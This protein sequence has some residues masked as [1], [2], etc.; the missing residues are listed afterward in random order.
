MASAMAVGCSVNVAIEEAPTLTIETLSQFVLK[1]DY[2]APV[3]LPE[4]TP[5][6]LDFTLEVESAGTDS[7]EGSSKPGVKHKVEWQIIGDHADTEFVATAGSVDVP[8]DDSLFSIS[9]TARPDAVVD[10]D[11]PFRLRI[12][13]VRIKESAT[14][15]VDLVIKDNTSP[16][17]L[18]VHPTFIN[19]GTS[20]INTNTDVEVEL[21]NVG[22]AVA[23]NSRFNVDGTGFTLVE[24]GCGRDLAAGETCKAKVR[25]SSATEL[26]GSGAISGVSNDTPTPVS[27][28]MIGSAISIQVQLNDTPSSRS[29]SIMLNTKVSGPNVDLY[30]FKVG[31]A[32]STNCSVETG[33]S[34]QTAHTT[35]IGSPLF[36]DGSYRL[37]VVGVS[38]TGVSQPL[39]QATVYNWIMDTTR[40]T[41][42]ISQSS[43]QL[44]PTR[45]MPIRF[46][47]AWS[48][49]INESTF[50]SSD[51][52]FIGT[53]EV[54]AYT[55]TKTGSQTW[56]VNV[57]TLAQPGTVQ[58]VVF[59]DAVMD[60]ADNPSNASVASDNSVT[61]DAAGPDPATFL[62][63][64]EPE[65]INQT[66]VHATW[67]P[68]IDD[69]LSQ[70]EIQF[71]SNT[72]CSSPIGSPV[73]L[74]KTTSTAS[75]TGLHNNTFT[76]RIRSL[77]GALNSSTS[78]CSPPITIDLVQPDVSAFSPV[79]GTIAGTPANV[80]VT[81]N[82]AMNAE[83]LVPARFT[84][85]CNGSGSMQVSGVSV[86]SA[87]QAR[88]NL[89]V[90]N[91]AANNERCTITALAGSKDVAGNLSRVGSAEY[92][93]DLPAWILSV[94][95]PTANGTYKAGDVILIDVKFNEI[96]TLSGAGTPTLL[97]SS[98][99]V[100][101]TASY[102]SGS[103]TTDLRFSYTVQ[104]GDNTEDL[105]YQNQSALV[106]NGANLRDSFGSDSNLTLP[107]M[108]S[109]NSLAGAKAII[110]D[111][112]PPGPFYITGVSGGTDNFKDI[113]LTDATEVRGDWTSATDAVSYR[114]SMYADDGTTQLCTS[115][116]AAGLFRVINPCA[117]TDLLYYKLRVEAFDA[118]GN[119]RIADGGFFRF[120]ALTGAVISTISDQPTGLTN[121]AN[122]SATVGGDNIIQY[123]SKIGPAASTDCTD[124]SG[125][126]ALT[127]VATP[128]TAN[129]TAHGNT[130]I[131]LCVLGRNVGLADQSVTDPTIATWTQ[132][133]TRPTVTINQR[134]GQA[135]PINT[136]PIQYTVVFSEA[137]SPGTFTAADITQSGTA[138]GITW[139]LST[140]D[141]ISWTA[142][143]TSVT[144]AGTIIPSIAVNTVADPAGNLNFAST[145]TDNSVTYDLTKPSVTVNQ[146]A[147]QTDPV[148]SLPIQFTVVFSEA[149]QPASF[150]VSD[151]RQ[152]GS[153]SGIVWNLINVNST[154]WTLQATSVG[155]AG[156][157]VPSI[158]ANQVLDIAGNQNNASTSTDNS[159]LYDITPPA[160]ATVPKWAVAS[161]SN[162]TTM[163]AQW[164]YSTSADRAS[165]SVRL[166]SDAACGTYTGTANAVGATVGTTT[167]TG[168]N[169]N[170]YTFNV[171]TTDTAGN[172]STSPCSG[173]M[174]IDTTAPTITNVTSATANGS[175]RVGSIIDVR[176]TFSEIVN[177]QGSPT[178]ALNT[179]PAR[180]ATYSGG[181]GSTTLVFSYT[182][183]AGD[184]VADLNY[185]AT[186]SLT[187]SA[188]ITI[189]DRAG[190][191]S[192]ITL[193][194]PAG[195]GSLGTNKNIEIDTSTPVISAFAVSTASP[196][197][198]TNWAITSTVNGTFTKYC[199]LEN[200]STVSSCSWIN[201]TS[202]P[203]SFTVTSTDG[204]KTLSLWVQDAA[205][206][207]SS[208]AASNSVTL[209]TTPPTAA[210]A[211]QP[212]GTSNKYSLN[213]DVGGTGVTLY[214]YKIGR[215]ST[216]TCSSATGY[217]SD[218]SAS[219]NV[220]ENISNNVTYPNGDIR[221]CVVG[222]D[223]AG[224][225][226][227]Y[228]SATTAQWT[229]N[230]PTVGFAAATSSVNEFG[231]PTHNVNVTLGRAL[232][233]TADVNVLVDYSIAG[234]G[235]RPATN[236]S[237]FT[238]S[239]GTLT[240]SAGVTSR[241]I[242]IPIL[243]DNRQEYDE[244]FAITLSNIRGALNGTHVSHT[245]T[246]LDDDPNPTII[247][248]DVSAIEGTSNIK[249][250]ATLSHA[251]DL[252]TVSFNW[253]LGSCSGADCATSGT[254]YSI[255]P[256]GGGSVSFAP[257]EVSKTFPS[258]A[259]DGVDSINDAVD[260][261]ARR[262]V[263]TASGASNGTL[264]RTSANVYMVDEDVPAGKAFSKVSANNYQ[265]CGIVSGSGV[266]KLMCWGSNL[267]GELGL[268]DLIER[269]SAT[270]VSGLSTTNVTDVSLGYA[271]TCAVDNGSAKCWGADSASDAGPGALG[272]GTT[273]S[274]TTPQQVSGMTSSVT[275][276]AAGYGFACG[277]QSGAVK[278]WGDNRKGQLGIA[279]ST[280]SSTSPLPIPAP[281]NG[282]V[283]SI[284][285]GQA[286][287]CGLK[288]GVVYCW[289]R[290]DNGELGRGTGNQTT[291]VPTALSIPGTVTDL[292][293]GYSSNCAKNN[294]SQVYCWGFN[295][296]GMLDTS[297]SGNVETPTRISALDN[298]T[299][300]D[301]GQHICGVVGGVVKCRGSNVTGALGTNSPT[302]AVTT[303]WTNVPMFASA[304]SAI[305]VSVSAAG[306]TCV[307]R[308][309]GQMFCF[310]LDS[311]GQL[312]ISSPV[313]RSTRTP[314][315]AWSSPHYATQLFENDYTTCGI[316]GGGVDCAG[317]NSQNMVSSLASDLVNTFPVAVRGLSSGVTDIG[318]NNYANCAIQSGAVKCWGLGGYVGNGTTTSTT[319]P[320]PTTVTGL[321]SGFTFIA[322]GPGN[323]CAVK[324][325]KA[326]CWGANGSGQLGTGSTATLVSTPVEVAISGK[327]I[328]DVSIGAAHIC[329]LAGG[330]V[331]CSGRNTEGQL[332]T[333][334]TTAR[335]TFA[336]V[337]GLTSGFTSLAASTHAQCALKSDK[338]LFCWGQNRVNGTSG[339]NVTTPTLVR[340]NILKVGAWERT[341]CAIEDDT[342][343]SDVDKL[344]CWGYFTLN[345][346]PGGSSSCS[347]AN[348]YC[349][350]PNL[351]T[352]L[353][354]LGKIV[355]FNMGSNR[356]CARGSGAST[357]WSCTGSDP[358]S[359][360]GT[361][362]TSV[363]FTPISIT[364]F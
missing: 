60:L 317:N 349:N 65:R 234:N 159:V 48:E 146:H 49:A 118:V 326:Y 293:V 182:V 243:D 134:A 26:N 44:D 140:S 225:W 248:R 66:E 52:R 162:N 250:L 20:L 8:E 105:D 287:V 76:Y 94:T 342:S 115:T 175:Y 137:I 42:T 98:G 154:T 102:V 257:G 352:E 114:L 74:S 144:G 249:M 138:T 321:T 207:V 240:F 56:E 153:A 38:S 273:G 161:P 334:N 57:S 111:T 33:Y 356:I 59:Q 7:T 351:H 139:T 84:Y 143:A 132:D 157:L 23:H 268:G 298:A 19:F 116:A 92:V 221:L 147:S 184:N 123:R 27:S 328:T 90:N 344:Y 327:S 343:A 101:R 198:Q 269:N 262:V 279:S 245:A 16:P 22:T 364:P 201:G 149:V 331:F 330:G 193:P 360:M 341:M 152:T 254:H 79:A 191:N 251:T 340:S 126:S 212:T 238:A 18:S 189:R 29:N 242:S 58:I 107:T 73:I 220:I 223:A 285:V 333:G 95:S 151:I 222:R 323:T 150:T 266:S 136:L 17:R 296:N 229:K 195:A 329:V 335:T 284:G 165:Q 112:T 355:D 39:T 82:E 280:T 275:S 345:E 274:A 167:F 160:A 300:V 346:Y 210:L 308:T 43:G 271:H 1:H 47:L 319:V 318:G 170:T 291:H 61:F 247:L 97:L 3:E 125:Y 15:E 235:T 109:A 124:I 53:A 301:F 173:A 359:S 25:F 363:F 314:A 186:N 320:N 14:S 78:A 2:T 357:Q 122:I 183:Q 36:A 142:S 104:A 292:W 211:G 103:G 224:N 86:L 295:P 289:G 218:V 299:R 187:A 11:K 81:F 332:G 37:C 277:L 267:N 88:V 310:G 68:A 108:G 272:R 306:H 253:S 336:E 28:P 348:K 276:V 241:A 197:N 46:T 171:V 131:R 252:A 213:I 172:Q 258:A 283:A 312:G 30:R 62:S 121:N 96:V 227:A 181:S 178:I 290:D 31:L 297:V 304:S 219:V 237:D 164:T 67:L 190:N 4:G 5:V 322:S 130:T 202:V 313:R 288:S 177:V 259:N 264:G 179:T 91:E 45:T 353:N 216:T 204:A 32:S 141:N 113:Y 337:P 119:I 12:Y 339:S 129:L 10:P 128:I 166:Y 260:N 270:D 246:I 294:S 311:V 302:T 55:L 169:N 117:T 362:A 93:Y 217:S 156:T 110:L 34:V 232:S 325:G 106:L 315:S 263:I 226:Q 324:S 9:L 208:R 135:D 231:S 358:N 155:V 261:I 278:C 120:R 100:P 176:I 228:A 255:T 72:T 87:T 163:T 185:V 282:S 286:H 6:T 265:T 309:G 239:S 133:L 71:H 24:N 13:G 354:G 54:S 89:T 80:V 83:S 200:I 127:P 281:M 361:D 236:G 85:I 214:R 194:A 99:E 40:P 205:G 256:V 206:N 230:F 41:V 307:I 192:S 69:D 196:T 305:D 347:A 233:G 199:L 35:P 168:S 70:Q 174:L 316:V 50:T 63:W 350:V 188:P 51:I 215:T 244:T 64:V 303:S 75:I 180:T 338:D 77:D 209:D 148:N 145:S 21:K 203:T 158:L